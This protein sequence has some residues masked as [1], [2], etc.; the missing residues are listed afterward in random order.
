M[1]V[2]SDMPSAV[3]AP[4]D[5]RWASIASSNNEFCMAAFYFLR[6]NNGATNIME[7]ELAGD[8]F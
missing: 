7:N 1:P 4:F 8:E 2:P 5:S 3:L 6:H